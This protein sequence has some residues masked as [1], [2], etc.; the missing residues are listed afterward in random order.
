MPRTSPL[1]ALTLAAALALSTTPALAGSKSSDHGHSHSHDD[2]AHDHSQ[3]DKAEA[4]YNGYFDDADIAPRPLSD[5]QGEWQSLYPYLQDGTLD[6]VMAH[7]AESGDKSAADYRAYYDTGYATDVDRITIAD[8]TVTFTSAS[9]TLTGTYA[10]DGYEILTYAKG[11]RGVRYIF[12]KTEGDA[13][14]PAYIQFSDH[15]IAPEP[16]DHY[17]LYW[18]NDRAALLDE[19]TN[20]PTYYPAALSG[21]AIVAEMLAH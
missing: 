8:D 11:N 6:P 13:D 1:T 16:A 18:G 14:A 10:S 20:W 5:W 3:D 12:A 7:K 9:A 15:R 4:I 17:H 19:V 21:A 2:H